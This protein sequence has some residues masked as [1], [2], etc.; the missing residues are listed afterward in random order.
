LAVK[1]V[2]FV[3]FVVFGLKDVSKIVTRVPNVMSL[4][5][6]NPS[7]LGNQAVEQMKRN[8]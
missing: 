2:D 1:E 3:I 4:I 5:Q 7:V 8:L 6:R